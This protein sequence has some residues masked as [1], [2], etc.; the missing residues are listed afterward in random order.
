MIELPDSELYRILEADEA[1]EIALNFLP[2]YPDLAKDNI[3]QARD[4]LDTLYDRFPKD[5]E[6]T[7]LVNIIMNQTGFDGETW[8]NF[9]LKGEK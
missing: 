4:Y 6:I 5:P 9:K 1:L 8:H 3:K 2:E 7:K